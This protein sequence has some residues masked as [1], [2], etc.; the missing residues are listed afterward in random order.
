[1]KTPY[2]PQT[3]DDPIVREVREAGDEMAR[4]AGYDLHALCEY[5]R[6]TER[7]HPERLAVRTPVADADR[8]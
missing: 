8:R 5:L 6:K 2:Y 4:A 1:M 3:F 7:E